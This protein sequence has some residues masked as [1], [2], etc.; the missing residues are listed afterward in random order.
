MTAWDKAIGFT[1]A[2]EGGYDNHPADR[3]GETF[4]GV[5][6]K[7]WP[8]WTGWMIIDQARGAYPSAS[9][10]AFHDELMKSPD[11]LHQATLFYRGNFWEPIHGDELP[12][13]VAAAL[14]DAAVHS[15]VKTAVRLLQSSI[16]ATVDGVVG[17][18]TI[19]AAFDKGEPGLVTFL[20]ARAKF[21]HELMAR[22]PSQEIWDM[23]WFRRLF[24]LANLVLDG[25]GVE[26]GGLA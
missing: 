7:N 12:G 21:L 5:S 3:G 6:R 4:R 2:Y 8:N 9:T 22:D 14:F 25:P 15:G 18:R 11:L 10:P 20:A 17:P 24:K 23:N 1:L 16:G 19:K 26:F 13:K